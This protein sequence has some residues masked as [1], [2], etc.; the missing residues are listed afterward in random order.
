MRRLLL[1]LVLAAA[2][3]SPAHGAPYA[4][5]FRGAD[6]VVDLVGADGRP[7][8]LAVAP[9]YSTQASSQDRRI[10]DITLSQCAGKRCSYKRRWQVL[11]KAADVTDTPAGDTLTVSTA[12]GTA[13][14]TLA[15]TRGSPNAVGGV[16]VNSAPRVEQTASYDAV[17][18]VTLAGVTC[19]NVPGHLYETHLVDGATGPFTEGNPP[20]GALPAGLLGRRLRC[21]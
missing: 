2:L 15:W 1:P 7:W 20:P 5:V 9:R 4:G 21:A 10:A 17:T 14:V 12:L 8:Q 18:T 13:P 3:A 16:Y 11:L 19:R 6:V